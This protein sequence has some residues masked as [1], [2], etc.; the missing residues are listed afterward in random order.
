MSFVCPV[1]NGFRDLDFTCPSCQQKTEDFGRF[2]DFYGPYSPYRPIDEYKLT[3]G[4]AGDAE[5]HRC[6]HIA[7]CPVCKGT[8][9]AAVDEQSF[10]RSNED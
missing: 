6:I 9:H 4:I 5:H 1:C 8:Y 7:F 2:H 3:N 10:M